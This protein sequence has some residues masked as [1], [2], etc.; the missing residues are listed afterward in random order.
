MKRQKSITVILAMTAVAMAGGY[1]WFL[2]AQNNA[3]NKESRS[4]QSDS[5]IRDTSPEPVATVRVVPLKKENVSEV[6]TAYGNVVPAPGATQTVSE[7]FET[8]IRHILVIAGQRVSMGDLLL[9]ID[10]GPDTRLQL[11]EARSNFSSAQETLQHMKQRFDLKLATNEQLL[12]A[13]QKFQEA[14]LRLENLDQRGIGEKKQVRSNVTGLIK[15]VYV[16]EGDI[17]PTGRPLMEMVAKDRIE[18]LLGVEPEDVNHLQVN[19]P[20]SLFPVN[21]PSP[22]SVTGRIRAISRSVNPA[23]RLIDAFVALPSPA[24]FLLGEYIQGRITIYSKEALVVPH[25][26][27]LPEGDH[28]ILFTVENGRARKQIVELGLE[29]EKDVEVIGKDLRTGDLVVVLG[30]YELKNGMAVKVEGSQ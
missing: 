7:P 22:R 23:T 20:V 16:H 13:K 28:Y 8:Q 5:T 12:Q 15:K 18:I 30:N 14:Q 6:I 10:P 26:V 19:Q 21:I 25:A 4:F 17:V 11:E 29:T 3:V 1:L 24:K 2:H 9:E 27:V